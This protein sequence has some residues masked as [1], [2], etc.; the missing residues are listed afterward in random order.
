MKVLLTGSTSGIGLSLLKLLV[1]SNHE[2]IAVGRN[3]KALASLKK[4]YGVTTEY[5]L[6]SDSSEVIKLHDKYQDR[7]DMLINCAGFGYLGYFQDNDLLNDLEMIDVNI[8]ALHILT[9]LFLKDFIKKDYGYIL[10]VGSSAGFGTGPL[11]ATYYATKNYVVKLTM[12]I[13][14]ELKK[15][16][17]KVVISCL[18]PGTVNTKFN[19]KI[20]I[21]NDK[22][23]LNSD[24][25]AKYALQQLFK[26]KMI[27]IPSLKMKLGV[28]GL[29]FIPYKMQNMIVYN[30][31]KKKKH[32]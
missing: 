28:F 11:M 5:V 3:K 18:C 14:G 17:S 13:N 30:I 31:E 24:D 25:V 22:S 1:K 20:N 10:N 6:L 29:R 32:V 4:E 12:A 27:I 21:S 9:S 19:E 15:Q 26:K 23:Y 2:V 7:I 16:K 8:K